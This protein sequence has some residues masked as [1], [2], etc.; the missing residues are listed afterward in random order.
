[1]CTTS[2]KLPSPCARPSQLV[3]SGVRGCQKPWRGSDRAA[4][5]LLQV[6][7]RSQSPGLGAGSWV[8]AFL[9]LPV[10][11]RSLN[12]A[13]K[14]TDTHFPF[15]GVTGVRPCFQRQGQTDCFK[16]PKCRLRIQLEMS[17]LGFY[18]QT[19]LTWTFFF[20]FSLIYPHTQLGGNEKAAG[21]EK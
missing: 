20:F 4:L 6:R 16:T 15:S 18:F 11:G 1:M 10:E 9:M 5:C 14:A 13:D 19:P 17:L 2:G 12:A 21:F 7:V 8:L 3:F